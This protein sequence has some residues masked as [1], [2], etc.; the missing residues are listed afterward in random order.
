MPKTFRINISLS[1]AEMAKVQR[2][3]DDLERM[4][5]GISVSQ[6]EAVRHLMLRDRRHEARLHHLNIHTLSAGVAEALHALDYDG[7]EIAKVLKTLAAAREKSRELHQ[8]EASAGDI[9]D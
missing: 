4:A 1:E 5:K 3:Q 6:P 7:D 8:L 2:I 9:N